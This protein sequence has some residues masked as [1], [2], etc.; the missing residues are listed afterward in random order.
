MCGGTHRASTLALSLR[1]PETV[2]ALEIVHVLKRFLLD[3]G[4]LEP[5]SRRLAIVEVDRMRFR[6]P[7]L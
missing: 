6:P 7:L 1:L 4:F 5:L 2:V 3:P